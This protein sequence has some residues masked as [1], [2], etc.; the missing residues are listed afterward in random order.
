MKKGST[1]LFLWVVVH[2]TCSPVFAEI[3]EAPTDKQ[4]EV[5]A[6]KRLEA[7]NAHDGIDR[8]EAEVIFEVYGYRF[9]SYNGWGPLVEGGENWLGTVLGHW[10]D[11]P[12]PHKIKI[13]KKTG[14]ISW[15]IGPDVLD[16]RVLLDIQP[17]NRFEYAPQGAGPR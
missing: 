16:Y 7:I 1:L 17:N 4:Y 14:A 10:S 6:R 2:I 11:R 8:N 15:A 3:S 13:D 5:G 9:F 12:L